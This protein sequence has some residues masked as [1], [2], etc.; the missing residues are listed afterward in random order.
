MTRL[1]KNEI[2]YL[3]KII[4]A[5]WLSI[6]NIIVFGQNRT[7][8][9][10]EDLLRKH[11]LIDTNRIILL[12]EVAYQFRNNNFE[13][14][15][16]YAEQAEKIS[17]SLNFPK[18]KA[19]SFR[20]KGLYYDR[21]AD[22]SK[23]LEYF[24]NSIKISEQ[25]GDKTG[26]S[27][28]FNSIGNIYRIQSD[29]PKALDNYFKS[30]KLA[31]ESRD[32]TMVAKC[33]NNVGDVYK[34]QGNYLKALEYFQNSLEIF[35]RLKDATGISKCYINI[36]RIY[37]YQEDFRKAI[38][39]YEK[40][41]PL[42]NDTKDK[43]GLL[44]CYLDIGDVYTKKKEF[45]KALEYLQ[46]SLTIA[47]ELGHK[48]GQAN[49]LKDIGLIY[50]Q[51]ENFEKAH[52]YFEKGQKIGIS[53]GSKSHLAWNYIGFS[54]IH[55]KLKETKM[56]L[57]YGLKAYS[58]AKETGELELIKTCSEALSQQYAALGSYKDAY[59]F[60]VLFKNLNDSLQSHENI[61]RLT[62]SEYEFEYKQ[63]KEKQQIE[64]EQQKKDVAYAEENRRNKTILF[65]LIGGL[66]Y[67]LIILIAG[68]ISYRDKKRKNVTLIIQKREISEKNE[69]L[70]QMNEEISA[71]RDELE[72]RSI[73]L[74]VKNE[75][76]EIQH[77]KIQNSITYASRIQSAILPDQNFISLLY[78][79]HFIMFRPRD[80]VSGDFYFVK[81][82]RNFS[83]VAA[84]D[85][86]GHGV[87]GAF[88]SLLGISSLNEI[89]T[90]QEITK[91]SLI[92]DELRIQIK[93]SLQQSGERGEQHDGMDIALCV[94][95][96]ETYEMSFSGA[97]NPCW[98][99]RTK[100]AQSDA[101]NNLESDFEFIELPSDRQ[102]VGV[103]LKERPFTEHTFQL[104]D[105]DIFYIFSDGFQSQFGDEKNEKFKINNFKKLLSNINLLPK[106]EQKQILENTFNNWKGKR[107]QTDDVLVIGIR[108]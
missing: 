85:C 77:L 51:M 71:Q 56:A 31:E 18:G 67:L 40:S 107:D 19:E 63:Q 42:L 46:K 43:L 100:N 84:A 44:Q 61:K 74:L 83:I 68:F 58:L 102:P 48:I 32:E 4:L 92:L 6:L 22:F 23:A 108:I 49:A 94:I 13:K 37:E 16:L 21:N 52:D 93:N 29:Y 41:L 98:I 106:Q 97:H 90:K 28:C 11:T 57:V 59:E 20:I 60:H 12:N 86:T 69:E 89:I 45:T 103:F 76:I 15:L 1:H 105:N 54:E 36:G 2:L 50:L 5:V 24:L 99:F 14:M 30:L 39:F 3:S 27:K 91:S 55:L 25:L 65:V 70:L 96:L 9:S 78:P 73:E 17:D 64:L 35:E 87:P 72:L 38:E 81:Q 95:N 10:L 82:F 75:K 79:E 7:S 66:I 47:K 8:D 80:I 62:A 34:F 33:Y 88:M 26:V 104:Q 53:I 101:H